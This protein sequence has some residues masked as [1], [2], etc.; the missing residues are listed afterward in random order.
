MNIDPAKHYLTLL[1]MRQDYQSRLMGCETCGSCESI[2]LSAT[3]AGPK[4]EDVKLPVLGC[5]QCGSIYQSYKFETQF[6]KDYYNKYYRLNLF[7]D[8]EIDKSFFLDQIKR[9][10]LLYKNL[11]EWIPSKGKLVDIGCSAGGLMI[12]FAKR[13]WEVNGNDPDR[14]YAEYGKMFGLNIETVSAE[15]TPTDAQADLIIINGSLEHVYDVN[16]VMSRCRSLANKNGL[17]LI[18]GRALGYGMQQGYLTHNHRRFLSP[19]SIELL[20][21]KHDWIPIMTTDKPLCG[22]TRPGAV[23]VLARAGSATNYEFNRIRKK[24]LSQLLGF[25]L[26][27]F[28]EQKLENI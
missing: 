6:Y 4:N 17:L 25:Y 8:T 24:N 27:W 18:E 14:A 22:P 7:G 16:T 12:P 10:N 19:Y 11:Q 15:E 26:P 20:M 9:G 5:K 1:N 2:L 21:L 23:F 3:V 28:S 13:G